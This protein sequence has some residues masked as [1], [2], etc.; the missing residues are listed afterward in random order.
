MRKYLLFILA[1]RIA[2][3]KVNKYMLNISHINQSIQLWNPVTNETR[4]TV[5]INPLADLIVRLW[6]VA[7]IVGALLVLLYLV[8]GAL[9]WIT[10]GGEADKVKEAKLRITN[11]FIGL[12]ILSASFAII[13]FLEVAFGFDLLNIEWPTPA[14]ILRNN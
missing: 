9:Q 2:V 13:I 14:S 4:D 12:A 5:S 8:M 10:A 11:A 1:S 7:V 6:N 3:K